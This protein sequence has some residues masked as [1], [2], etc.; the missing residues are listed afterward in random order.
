LCERYGRL[1]PVSFTC[2]HASTPGLLT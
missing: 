2:Y 1:G